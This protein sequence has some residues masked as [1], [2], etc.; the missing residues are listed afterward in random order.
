MN[1][2]PCE[3]DSAKSNLS[4]L[5]IYHYVLAAVVVLYAGGTY[6]QIWLVQ[7]MLNQPALRE[8]EAFDA[9]QM[10]A[11]ITRFIIAVGV[12]YLIQAFLLVMTARSLAKCRRWR[13]CLVVSHINLLIFPFGTILG[14]LTI[15]ALLKP[16]AKQL[17]RG[18]QS[19]SP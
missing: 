12:L 5:S 18:T 6:F 16:A 15:I 13:F 19:L 17:F 14:V 2:S 3:L 4:A 9:R 7:D 1:D 10:S 8:F 11:N